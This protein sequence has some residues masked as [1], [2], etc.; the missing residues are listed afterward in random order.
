MKNPLLPLTTGLLALI[1]ASSPAFADPAAS[2]QPWTENAYFWQ[3]AGQPVLL[4]GGSVED[5]LFQIADIEEELD[6]LA[7]CGG[8]YVRCTLS[9]RDEGNPWPFWRD[10]ETGLYDLERVEGPFWDNLER[11]IHLTR[12]RGIIL[13]LEIFDRFD[14][15]RDNW[16]LNPFNPRN[17]INYNEAESGLATEYPGHPS[18]RENGF[19][20]SVPALEDN[21]LL[22]RYQEAFVDRL[23]EITLGQ[24]HVLYCISN[25]TNESPDWGA[26]W[27][28]YIHARAEDAGEVVFVTEMWNARELDHPDHAHT[29]AHPDLYGFVDISQVNH[30]V[31]KDHWDNLM[32]FRARI[33]ATG[34]PRPI[35]T[36][37][38]YGANTGSYGNNRDA[39]ERFWR[40]ILAGVAATRFHRPTSGIGLNELAQTHIR[41]ARMFADKIDLFRC[42]PEA[43]QLIW[44]SVNEAY[45]TGIP[46]ETYGLF[47]P[48]GGHVTLALEEPAEGKVAT[49]HWLD[50]RASQWLEAR[51]VTIG[52]AGRL[53][54]ETPVEEGYWAAVLKM[55]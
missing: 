4:L 25:E 38:I 5:N 24:P 53:V 9:S 51:E 22:R 13:Q 33:A 18:R 55:P 49:L 36:V 48:D 35:N 32:T 46:G 52:P 42:Q 29:Y 21:A 50:I 7:A 39:Q 23:L 14:Y 27:A 20:R 34:L 31:G 28:R 8:N 12:E 15:A 17:N 54:I 16:Q 40:N 10:P 43:A 3:I 47:F 2:I 44:P 6:R 19:F 30:L 1:S 37:K 45:V 26:S 11:F 41:S